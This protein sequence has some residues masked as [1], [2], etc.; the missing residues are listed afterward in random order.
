MESYVEIYKNRKRL[1]ELLNSKSQSKSNSKSKPK[2]NNKPKNLKN[3]KKLL[4][5]NKLNKTYEYIH[6]DSFEINNINNNNLYI[7]PQ[8]NFEISKINFVI[9]KNDNINYI[10]VDNKKN[11]DIDYSYKESI[12]DINNNSSEEEIEDGR[13]HNKKYE[14]IDK[15]IKDYSL[16]EDMGRNKNMIVKNYSQNYYNAI[17][18]IKKKQKNKIIYPIKDTENN[19]L[20]NK[21]Q[22]IS[23]FIIN[24]KNN[25]INK[26]KNNYKERYKNNNK[27][28]I[29]DFVDS[30]LDNSSSSDNDEHIKYSNYE[31][32]TYKIKNK[33]KENLDGIKNE[34]KFYTKAEVLH[35]THLI[36]L[37]NST[38]IKRKDLYMMSQENFR[39][40][41]KNLLNK[42]PVKIKQIEID[43]IFKKISKKSNYILYSQFNDLLLELIR[44][45]FPENYQNNKKYT[46]NYFLNILF[47]CFSSLLIDEKNEL[48]NIKNY[49]Y[50]SIMSLI[51]VAP[52]ENQIIIIKDILYTIYQI[53]VK[54][55]YCEFSNDTK[56][57]FES[58]K[59][60]IEFSKDFEILP[61][62]LNETQIVTYYKLVIH[63][64]QPYKFLEKND[65]IGIIFTL[66]HFILYIIHISLYSFS[67]R[68]ENITED[69]VDN[70]V[71]NESKLLLFLERMESSNGMKIF[72]KKL[73]RPSS[74]KLTF[75]PSKDIYYKVGE[76][77]KTGKFKKN[78]VINT[79]IKSYSYC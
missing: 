8:K 29:E 40:M 76:L 11:N 17:N 1:K 30:D 20:Q 38:Y 72:R 6:N 43:L 59:N 68:Y 67:K 13:D 10:S 27:I 78:K 66:N 52:N 65:N 16:D 64:E 25:N 54:Y 57:I 62:I 79:L 69:I 77:S 58:S 28:N 55:F 31:Y 9:H 18:E 56:M 32:D 4:N 73:M 50:N 19:K 53:Y 3:N 51:S 23:Q 47:R 39:K 41:V 74:G 46:I 36:F 21:E 63:Y 70:S 60:L 14:I 34:I 61:Y 26:K 7:K 48:N 71:S 33:K 42:I 24:K 35:N 37:N 12:N 45:L 2:K 22:I 49:K 44:K 5:N 75:I 15:K